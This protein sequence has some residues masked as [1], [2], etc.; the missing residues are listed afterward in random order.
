MVTSRKLLPSERV[1]SLY[2]SWF[3]LFVSNPVT[4]HCASLSSAVVMLYNVSSYYVCQE[5]WAFRRLVSSFSCY[6]HEPDWFLRGLIKLIS[7]RSD[8]N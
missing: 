7:E 5:T 3:H 6:S 4:I 8:D 1:R 2:K